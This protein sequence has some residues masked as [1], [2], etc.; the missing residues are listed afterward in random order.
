M[1][2]AFLGGGARARGD[3]FHFAFLL[4]DH[5]LGLG[6]GAAPLVR[7]SCAGTA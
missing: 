3:G 6:S 1:I 2:S 5:R 7:A 4:L